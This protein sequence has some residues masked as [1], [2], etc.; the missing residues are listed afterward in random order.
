MTVMPI[1]KNKEHHVWRVLKQFKFSKLGHF[2][3]LC[4]DLKFN[5]NQ[6]LKPN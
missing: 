2:N 6:R 3:F 5:L 4:F 1:R